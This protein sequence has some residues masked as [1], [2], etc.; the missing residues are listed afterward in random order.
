MIGRERLVR[1]GENP[2]GG[3]RE[4]SPEELGLVTGGWDDDDHHKRRRRRRRRR[5]R[6]HHHDDD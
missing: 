6:K 1:G 4:L 5:R 2:M 3:L